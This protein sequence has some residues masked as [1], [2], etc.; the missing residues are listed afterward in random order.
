PP[1]PAAPGMF[2]CSQPGMIAGLFKQVGF[3]NIKEKE[4]TGK[5]AF[6][7]FDRYWEIMLDIGAPI[8]A[9]LSGAD[10]NTKEIIKAEVAE[11]FKSRSRDASASLDYASIIV[12]GEK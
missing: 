1:P 7:S 5:V 6:Q 2:R 10:N 4:I 3:K 9:A 8:V 11:L 12:Y